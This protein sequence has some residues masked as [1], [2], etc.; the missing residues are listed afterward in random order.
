MTFN[1]K[2]VG[3]KLSNGLTKTKPNLMNK[4]KRFGEIK[5]RA[6]FDTIETVNSPIAF[7]FFQTQSQPEDTPASKVQL[8]LY[9]SVCV[10][11]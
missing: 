4:C 2:Q 10:C 1:L 6:A 9:I 8:L 5:A 7:P 11:V 3:K